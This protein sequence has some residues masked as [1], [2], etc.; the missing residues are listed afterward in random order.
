M[1]VVTRGLL[2]CLLLAPLGC[3]GG[4]DDDD[5]ADDDGGVSDWQVVGQDQPAALL[6]VWGSSES[7]VWAVGGDPGDDGGPLVFHYEGGEWTRLDSGERGVD[8]WWVFGFE[9]G[10]VFMSGS[11]GTILRY[12]DGAFEKFTT[13]GVSIVFGMWGAAPD[14]VWAVGG[15]NGGGSGFVWRFDGSEWAAAELPADIT[16][17]DTVWKVAGIAADDVWMSATA[18]KTLHWNGSSLDAELV[19]GSGASLTSVGGNAERFIAVGG[20]IFGEI[21]E[22]AGDGWESVLEPDELMVGV[23]VSDDQAYAVGHFGTILRRE[24]DGWVADGEPATEENLHAAWIDPAG[25]VWTVGG[26]F[27]ARPTTSGVLL[28][29]GN[30]IEGSLP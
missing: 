24:S 17:E 10:P 18:A 26:Q 28:H 2:V 8:L 19:P 3:G 1:S 9:G 12:Q 14:D 4:D 25:G 27:D 11:A 13:P 30:V 5:D 29:N 23:A 7:D 6:S 22:N 20:D 21:F 16:G 15:N